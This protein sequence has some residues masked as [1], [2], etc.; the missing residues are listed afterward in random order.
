[1]AWNEPGNNK[2]GSGGGNPWGGPPNN[3]GDIQDLFDKL[4]GIFGGDNNELPTGK[5]AILI[6]VALLLAWS[7]FGFYQLDEQKRAVVLRLGAFHTIVGPGI[8][9][10]PPFIDTVIRENVTQQRS[11]TTQGAML[12]EDENIVDVQLSVQYNIGDLRKFTMSIRDPQHA[13][14]EATDSAVR[15]AIGS[16]KMDD[17]LTVGRDKIAVDV[18]SRLQKYLDAY[19]TG[20]VVTTV[21][22]EKT[23]PP[24][25]VQAAFDDVIKARE[26]EQ[27]VQNEA[28]TY[29]NTVIPEAR[30]LAKRVFEESL[31]YRD[32]A[33]ARAQGEAERFNALLAEYRKAPDVTRERLY[34][35]AMQ[36]IYSNNSKVL[37]DTQNSSNVLYLPLDQLKNRN[38]S[39][40]AT[41]DSTTGKTLSPA[42]I[43]VLSNQLEEKIRN[44]KQSSGRAD[45]TRNR[46]AR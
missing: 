18:Q 26:D 20:I 12:T 3:K 10:N 6:S 13:L 9:W 22:V 24:G 5:L 34:I 16:S 7:G 35:E 33:I 4:G 17:V 45:S 39:T 28:Q 44:N 27:R 37:I 38:T 25:A 11:Y 21:N 31:A 42:E 36:E 1:M 46:E 2:P 41:T 19:N 8:H 40:G 29:A 30:G 32:R 14:E 15:H 23:Q 43:D